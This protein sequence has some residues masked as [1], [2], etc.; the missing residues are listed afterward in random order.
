MLTAYVEVTQE[1]MSDHHPYFFSSLFLLFYSPERARTLELK[2]RLG[3]SKLGG[4]FYATL[5][6]YVPQYYVLRVQ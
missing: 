1:V 5:S 3:G 6:S 4:S 2:F